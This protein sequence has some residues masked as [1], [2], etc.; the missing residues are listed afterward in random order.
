MEKFR[1]SLLYEL[2]EGRGGK[3]SRYFVLVGSDESAERLSH[4]T[5]RLRRDLP[6]NGPFGRPWKNP[7]L[8]VADCAVMDIRA[9][10]RRL[11]GLPA[12]RLA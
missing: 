5:F 11:S 2:A 6:K 4:S 10:N 7:M 12:V 9:W 3:P 1:D 8:L